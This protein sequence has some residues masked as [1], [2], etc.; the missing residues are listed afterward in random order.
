MDIVF[1]VAGLVK[2][3]RRRDLFSVNRG[4]AEALGEAIRTANHAP[5]RLVVVS[6]LAARGPSPGKRPPDEGGP[7]RPV[8]AYGESKLAGEQALSGLTDTAV[9]VVRPPIVY[10]AR[11][12][13]FL[14]VFRAVRSG[15]VVVPGGGDRH[16]SIVHVSDLVRGM[17]DAGLHEAT[18][19]RTYTLCDGRIRTWSEII[20]AIRS[21]VRPGAT[22]L[23]L[24]LG[25]IGV[26]ALFATGLSRVTGTPYLLSLDKLREIRARAW[27]CSSDRARTDFGYEARVP[28][29][30][31]IRG[32]A[33]WYRREGWLRSGRS[34]DGS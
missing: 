33:E 32:T 7:D 20:E 11:D 29:E 28:F 16:Y 22:T 23:R 13:N 1:H 10:G 18:R 15:L 5:R 14:L 17:V 30:E 34:Q 26:V 4:G 3:V 2:A 6:S 19:G 25:L 27:V 12:P 31:G 9:T 21:E 24:P 8:S